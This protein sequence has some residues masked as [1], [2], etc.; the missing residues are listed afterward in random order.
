MKKL[1]FIL[2]S[3][4]IIFSSDLF[5]QKKFENGIFFGTSVTDF[6][7][8]T[9]EFSNSLEQGIDEYTGIHI[10]FSEK[11]RVLLINYGYF[12]N[13]NFYPWLALRSGLEY[14][15]KGMKFNG[16]CQLPDDDP[17]DVSTYSLGCEIKLKVDYIEIPIAVQLSTRSKKNPENTYV[18]INA[19]VS[20]SILIF[21][22]M[23]VHTWIQDDIAALSSAYNSSGNSTV[24]E[25]TTKN[26][27][28][29]ANTFD[30]GL[31]GSFGVF[32]SNKV[33][34]E[35]KYESGQKNIISGDEW[36]FK[37]IMYNLKMGIKF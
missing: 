18:Y 23:I 28:D 21:S 22:R 35:L 11:S 1:F 25:E 26:K 3:I 2:I 34:F 12:C 5:A 32:I 20:P 29:D 14:N 31:F 19:G 16:K 30:L 9:G 7:G 36:N 33:S 27:I 4:S 13:F 15:P 10:P 17:F 24:D 6:K 8:N 37:N